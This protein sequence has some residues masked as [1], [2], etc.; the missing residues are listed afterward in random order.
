MR[1]LWQVSLWW[2]GSGLTV[3]GIFWGVKRLEKSGETDIVKA[4]KRLGL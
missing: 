4:F 3:M 1:I 2:M